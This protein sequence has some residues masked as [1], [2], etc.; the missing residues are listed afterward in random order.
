MP[1]NGT[2]RESLS[3]GFYESAYAQETPNVFLYLLDVYILHPGDT[4]F[5][6]Y[7]YV[8]DYSPLT[9]NDGGGDVIYQPSSFQINLGNDSADSTPKVT[10]NFDSGDRTFI[11]F[12]RE[13][14]ER[15]YVDLSVAMTPYDITTTITGVELGPIRLEADEFNFKAT[16]VSVN[17]IAESILNEPCPSAK[18]SPTLAPALWSGIPVGT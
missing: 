10:L 12:L 6:V 16:A 13:T 14:D 3:T 18:M 9:F 4:T 1:T 15:P 7:H 17:L 2:Y 11:R 8:N 5:S